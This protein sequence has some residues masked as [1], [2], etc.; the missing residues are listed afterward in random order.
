MNDTIFSKLLRRKLT[1]LLFL[2]QKE[3]MAVC[4]IYAMIHGCCLNCFCLNCFEQPATEV[5]F[6]GCWAYLENEEEEQKREK[7]LEY[8]RGNYYK[9]TTV[10]TSAK[11]GQEQYISTANK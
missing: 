11:M 7:V 4:Y 5:G 2:A 8:N 9:V 10:T 3:S 1:V 6:S